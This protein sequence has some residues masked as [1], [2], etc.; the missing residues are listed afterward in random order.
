MEER[1]PDSAAGFCRRAQALIELGRPEAALPLL[2]QAATADPQDHEPRCIMALALLNLGRCA[3]GLSAA[4]EAAALA[5]WDEWPHRLRSL[6]LARL[7]REREALEAAREAVRAAPEEPLALFTLATTEWTSGGRAAAHATA[8]RLQAAAP[9]TAS[10][11]R[12]LA[13][14]ALEEKRFPE[15]ERQS[16]KALELEAEYWQAFH[17]LGQALRGQGRR[18]EAIEAFYQAARLNPTHQQ[19][20]LDLRRTIETDL[21]NGCFAVLALVVLMLVFI[22]GPLLPKATA[23]RLLPFAVALAPLL[24]LGAVVR[25]L[26]KLRDLPSPVA[27]FY[28]KDCWRVR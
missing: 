15:A 11:Y 8:A 10:T 20:R 22:T 9:E 6:L 19:S 5:P 1:S 23:R 14:L 3:E 28:R 2:R 26:W 13:W 27:D 7:G 4:E 16:R 17:Y 12:L 18:S 21:S 25:Y 24:A